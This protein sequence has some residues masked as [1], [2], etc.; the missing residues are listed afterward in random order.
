MSSQPIGVFDSGLGGLTAVKQ[1]QKVLPNENIVYF[2]DTGRVPYGNRSTDIIKKYALQDT[3]FLISKNVKLVIAACGT[4]SSVLPNLSD[5]TDVPYTG[6][7]MPTAL[8]AVKATHNGKIGVI[9][10]TATVKSRSYERHIHSIDS[11]IEVFQQDCPLFVPLVENGFIKRDDP[12][13]R[14]AAERYLAGLKDIGVDTLILGCT[15]YPILMDIISDYMGENV[16]LINSGRETA[17]Y[18]AE[19]LNKSGMLNTQNAKGTYEYYVSDCVE[20][21][22]SVARVFLGSEIEHNVQRLDI[23]QFIADMGQNT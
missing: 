17:L 13:P 16:K 19:L 3:A 21:F 7:L 14:M 2:G 8:A 1:L 20:T 6:V 12:I 4:V 15:H 9:G 11:R 22:S 10:T 5:E 18:A 23:E